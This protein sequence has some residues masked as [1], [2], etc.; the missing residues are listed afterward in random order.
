MKRC[1]ASRRHKGPFFTVLIFVREVGRGSRQ[2]GYRRATQT[3]MAAT[4]CADCLK[5]GRVE[6]E[7]RDLLPLEVK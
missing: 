1:D 5:V 4:L 3:K 6:A 7:G 2:P